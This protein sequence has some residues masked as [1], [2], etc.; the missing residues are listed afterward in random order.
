MDLISILENSR[1][2]TIIGASCNPWRT[3]YQIAS[4][5]KQRGYEILPVN[6]N[7]EEVLG[8]PCVNQLTDLEKTTR[9]DIVNIF[10]RAEETAGAVRQVADWKELTG[11]KPVVWTQLGVSSPEA[12][13][14]AIDAELPYVKNRCIKIEY[15]RL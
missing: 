6:P 5:L 11:Q 13:Q 8:E 10:R 3:S 4:F 12:E 2:I 14:L 9:I 7:Y 1:T 15:E